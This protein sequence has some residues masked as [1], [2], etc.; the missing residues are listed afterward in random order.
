MKNFFK[1]SLILLL[2]VSS[3]NE[4]IEAPS[5]KSVKVTFKIATPNESATKVAVD[6]LTCYWTSGDAIGLFTENNSNSKFTTTATAKVAAFSGTITSYTTPSYL[7][8]IYPWITGKTLTGNNYSLSVDESVI[9]PDLYTPAQLSNLTHLVGVSNNKYTSLDISESVDESAGHVMFYHLNA[10]MSFKIT[11]STGSDLTIHSIRMRTKDLTN[12][13]ST[14]AT[15]KMD[16]ANKSADFPNSTDYVVSAANS[17]IIKI[18]LA[19]PSVLNNG[20]TVALET[21]IFPI[22]VDGGKEFYVEVETA[23]NV[24]YR[25]LKKIKTGGFTFERGKNYD[26]AANLNATSKEA[27]D[28]IYPGTY[29]DG[30]KIGSLIFAPVNVG[31][32]ETNPNGKLFQW[33]RKYGQ[34]ASGTVGTASATITVENGSL[35]SNAN[36]FYTGG[37]A[38]A[39]LYSNPENTTNP[40]TASSTYNP[41]PV[42]WRVPTFAEMETLGAGTLVAGQGYNYGTTPNI[43]FLPAM[44]WRNYAGTIQTPASYAGFYWTATRISNGTTTGQQ[45]SRGILTGTSTI[46]ASGS[47]D[48]YTKGFAVRCIRN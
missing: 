11:N 29:V 28:V 24:Y 47:D 23:D 12:V 46:T 18:T 41:C 27:G 14:N 15:I 38:N 32:D 8:F 40:W 1:L 16:P 9:Q 3:C 4:K 22:T 19:T 43:V 10:K 13:F 17:N 45:K 30:T 44:N 2:F 37:N 34:N 20:S 48:A 33:H 31:K 6:G 42:A 39:T 25:E 35:L 21:M 36:T 26:I 5:G 7:Y